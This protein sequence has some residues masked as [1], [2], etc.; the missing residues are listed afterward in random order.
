[1]AGNEV[2]KN[3]DLM[4]LS[5]RLEVLR[6]VLRQLL[7]VLEPLE[8]HE[9]LLLLLRLERRGRGRVVR[10]VLDDLGPIL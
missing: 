2:S 3:G 10:R 1:L 7:L 9:A 5:G 4:L 8:A 6:H